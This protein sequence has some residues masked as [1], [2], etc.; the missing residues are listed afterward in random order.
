MQ[1]R[2]NCT[3]PP[4]GE[5]EVIDEQILRK[6][7]RDVT[8]ITLP[9]SKAARIGRMEGVTYRRPKDAVSSK[10]RGRRRRQAF[11][12]LPLEARVVKKGV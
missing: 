11:K 8:V 7:I 4:A 9:N 3:L 5:N 12:P 10:G 6:Q 2:S 1:V